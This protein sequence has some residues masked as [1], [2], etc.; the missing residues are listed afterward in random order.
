MGSAT[1]VL[2]LSNNFEVLA[3]PSII[4][5][6]QLCPVAK[7]RS[8]ANLYTPTLEA[9]DLKS[10]YLSM[11]QGKRNMW[12]FLQLQMHFTSISIQGNTKGTLGSHTMDFERGCC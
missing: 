4:T 10:L 7:Y 8:K 12:P 9:I 11:S 2:K 5:T 6:Q 1:V 3:S